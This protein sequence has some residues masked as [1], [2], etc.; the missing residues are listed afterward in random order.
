MNDQ[1]TYQVV[2]TGGVING[3]EESTA[4]ASFAKVFS[5]T[6]E[7]AAS[8]LEPDRMVNHRL[9]KSRAADYKAKIESLGIP[10]MV[11]LD[12][13]PLINANTG[14]VF[15]CPKC[16][17]EQQK[18]IECIGCG[19]IFEKYN[20]ALSN[21]P[22]NQTDALR[23]YDDVEPVNAEVTS[24]RPL[25]AFIASAVAA[26]VCALICK[27]LALSSGFQFGLLAW[28]IG[29]AVGATAV[30]AGGRGNVTGGFCAALALLAIFGGKYM[31]MSDQHRDFTAILTSDESTKHISQIYEQ[32]NQE[33]REFA[34]IDKSDSS[35]KQ[36]MIDHDYTEADALLFVTDSELKTFRDEI[37]PWLESDN[38]LG[39]Y[40]YSEF[41]EPNLAAAVSEVSPMS[42]LV[43]SV[44]LI[45]LLF[46]F[47]GLGTTF[48]LGRAGFG[49]KVTDNVSA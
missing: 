34:T 35:V 14:G 40:A 1:D 45:D 42:M 27:L 33:A 37:Q 7:K 41:G 19:I 44:G 17:R 43:K 13:T 3:F 18:A 26:I 38:P 24:R 8:Y 4:I 23:I 15:T 6:P 12:S 48:Q 28:A 39:M 11:M 22:N 20:A 5:I 47:F 21:N 29:G 16:Q 2:S 25:I 46:I 30:I 31:I 32:T 36:F 49:R 9:P 10:V